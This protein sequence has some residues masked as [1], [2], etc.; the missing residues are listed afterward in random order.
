MQSYGQRVLKGA[1]PAALV[2]AV[3][4]YFYA[5]MAGT[6]HASNARASEGQQAQDQAAELTRQL[7]LRIPI[8][9]ALWGVAF[10][11]AYEAVRGIWKK[12]TPKSALDQTAEPTTEQK[13]QALLE[14]IDAEPP[15]LAETPPPASCPAMPIADNT[16]H[17]QHA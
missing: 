2:L 9:M 6:W 10:V 15:M 7:K 3:C 16:P 4:G 14:T 17:G 1:I 5:Q 12:P 13:L 11:A 8:T